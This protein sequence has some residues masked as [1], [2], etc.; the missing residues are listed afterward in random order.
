MSRTYCLAVL[1]VGLSAAAARAQEGP[2]V[3]VFPAEGKVTGKLAKA[4]AAVTAAV[5]DAA[6]KSGARVEVAKGSMADA[7]TLAGCDEKDP[8]CLG[9]V[10]STTDAD[11]V[12]SISVAPADTGVFVDV[13]IGKRDAA[14]PTHANWILDGASVAAIQAAASK[15][16]AA[17]FGGGGSSP[18]SSAPAATDAAEPAAQPTRLEVPPDAGAAPAARQ[19]EDR[20]S[21][22]GRVRW[23]AWGTTGVGAALLVGGAL[24]LKGAQSKQDDIDA[25]EP[26]TLSDFRELESLEDDA[27]SQATLGN[28]MLGAGVVAAGIGVTMII[29][30]VR[31]SPDEVDTVS[32]APTVLDHGAGIAL[33][34][35][36]DP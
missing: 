8:G 17:L 14:E 34:L 19:G 16:A 21:G 3:V 20:P 11:L 27:S 36:G 1:L 23:Y 35:R 6:R 12:L 31:S 2:R 7:M 28:L 33:T 10:A 18:A 26:T 30:E 13:D 4:P 32:I 25:A 5:A 9:K 15:E 29:L 22:L 24:F